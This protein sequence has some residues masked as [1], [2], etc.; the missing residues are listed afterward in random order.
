MRDLALGVFG[1]A[2]PHYRLGLG[3]DLP[4]WILLV[5]V[6]VDWFLLVDIFDGLLEEDEQISRIIFLGIFGRSGLLL[7]DGIGGWFGLTQYKLYFECIAIFGQFAGVP[8]TAVPVELTPGL[9]DI[10]IEITSI[11]GILVDPAFILAGFDVLSRL[12]RLLLQLVDSLGVEGVWYPL[13]VALPDAAVALVLIS[14]LNYRQPS[15][16]IPLKRPHPTPSPPVS[17]L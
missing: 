8:R 11:F 1:S 15:N 5:G 10:V 2:L 7:L 4:R 12:S 3:A 9:I 6:L 16:R 13:P 14:H 17:C